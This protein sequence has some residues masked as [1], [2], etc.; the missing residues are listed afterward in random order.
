LSQHGDYDLETSVLDG[1]GI[2]DSRLVQVVGI[3]ANKQFRV[4]HT[5]FQGLQLDGGPTKC[6]EFTENALPP[7]SV[8]GAFRD[9]VRFAS[10]SAANNTFHR[11]RTPFERKAQVEATLDDLFRLVRGTHD[12][13]ALRL[14]AL[15]VR[16]GTVGENK[17]NACTDVDQPT[18]QNELVV[19]RLLYADGEARQLAVVRD[20]GR[21]HTLGKQ[22]DL[23]LDVHSSPES[24][25]QKGTDDGTHRV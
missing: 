14:A 21:G 11:G 2:T 25:V 17:Q 9:G 1:S 24:N 3:C 19:A 13:S 23:G 22:G 4:R 7:L 6:G 15:S 20:R 16:M 10:Q 5:V 8:F 12:E 18:T